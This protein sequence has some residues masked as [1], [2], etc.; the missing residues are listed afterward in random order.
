MHSLGVNAY[1]FSISW[2]RILPRGRFGEVNPSG[3]AFYNKII[4]LLV[5]RGVEPFVTIHHNDFPKELEDRYG[6]WLSPQMQ[7][8]FVHYAETCYREFGDRVKYWVT[9]N[10]PN[11]YADLAYINGMFP[12]S[13][14]SHPY[15]TNSTTN[16]GNSNREFLVAMHNMLLAHAKAAR[17]YRQNFQPRQGGSIGIVASAFMYE[18]MTDNDLDEEAA[19][20]ALACDLA[21]IYDPLVLGDYPPE[22]KHYHGNQLPR[23]SDEEKGYIKD[24]VD[25]IGINHYSTLYAKDCFYSGCKSE[26]N[27]TEM[28]I[29]FSYITGERGGVPIGEPTAMFGMYVVPRGMEEIISYI[30]KRYSNKP[31]YVLENGYAQRWEEDIEAPETLNDVKRVEFHKLYLAHL[32]KAIRD[33]ADVRGYFIWTLMDD[34]EWLDGYSISFGLYYIDRRTLR[35]TPKLSAKWYRSFLTNTS[36][37]DEEVKTI[38]SRNI[39]FPGLKASKAEM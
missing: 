4:D 23:F 1:R 14:I 35:R 17:L 9:I 16:T 32:A 38:R 21:W 37:G 12:P 29:G 25:F 36:L 18:P 34:F 6:S 22:M 30:K 7:E 2:S 15:N 28:I 27:N 3:V 33:G 31:I 26:R 5:L 8:D 13:H 24:S 10:E 19:S 20:R 39:I 11:L